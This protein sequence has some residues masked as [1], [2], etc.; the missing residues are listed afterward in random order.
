MTIVLETSASSKALS[1][2]TVSVVCFVYDNDNSSLWI[3]VCYS[4]ISTMPASQ[5]LGQHNPESQE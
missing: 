4:L 5:E 1:S 3:H 2:R